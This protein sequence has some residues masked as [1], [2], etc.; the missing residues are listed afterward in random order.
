MQKSIKLRDKLQELYSK[1]PI[2]YGKLFKECRNTHLQ[3]EQRRK[4]INTVIKIAKHEW[5]SQETMGHRK[6]FDI[7]I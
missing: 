4:I 2:T 7:E 5:K 1:W 6:F 3:S